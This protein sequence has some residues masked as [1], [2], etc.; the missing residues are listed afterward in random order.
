MA[1]FFGFHAGGVT[2]LE[3]IKLNLIVTLL[4]FVVSPKTSGAYLLV[5]A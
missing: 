2:N 4:L 3:L 5:L 1:R